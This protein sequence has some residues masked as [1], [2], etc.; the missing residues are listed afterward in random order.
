MLFVIGALVG[1]T[2]YFLMS[3]GGN[4]PDS[5]NKAVKAKNF[6]G[7]LIPSFKFQIKD[8]ELHIHHWLYLTII[9]L[10][11]FLFAGKLLSDYPM[12]TGF[13]V[14]GI[15]EGLRYKDRFKL[16]KKTN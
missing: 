12:I 9:F 8:Y 4:K 7:S 15:I 13:L 6:L 16:L 5:S 1:F 11:L 2:I 3:K 14:G 10:I